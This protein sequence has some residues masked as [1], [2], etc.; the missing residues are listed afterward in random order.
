MSTFASRTRTTSI[1]I[2][3]A[4]VVIAN[5]GFYLWN[6]SVEQVAKDAADKEARDLDRQAKAAIRQA[7]HQLEVSR[8]KSGNG[9]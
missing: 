7:E 8:I 1:A 4:L 5:I 2:V 3:I 6:R 9:E